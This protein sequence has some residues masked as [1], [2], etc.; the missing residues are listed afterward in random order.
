MK[1]L[2]I[3]LL[4]FTVGC[5]TQIQKCEKV[6]SEKVKQEIVDFLKA[7]NESD[8]EE[9]ENITTQDY[10]IYLD[11]EVL[12]HDEFVG[13]IKAFPEPIDY[14]FDDFEFEIETD[15]NSAFVN[16]YSRGVR[17]KDDTSQITV[18]E[19]QSAYIKRIGN[20]LKLSFLHSTAGKQ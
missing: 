17:S 12:N 5:G 9:I 8:F 4:V 19:L 16:Y 6:D 14:K 7:T 11:G 20:E 1:N 2:L 13:F 10:L 15:C 3:L 18:F